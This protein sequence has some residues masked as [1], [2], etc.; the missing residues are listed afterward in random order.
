MN[1]Y[2]G[3]VK[4]IN[5]E[6]KILFNEHFELSQTPGHHN[7]RIYKIV[8]NSSALNRYDREPVKV[9]KWFN[10][11]WLYVEV[12]F[13]VKKSRTRNRQIDTTLTNIS[14]SVYEGEDNDEIKI[15]LFRAEW[16]DMN[17]N[18]EKHA[19]P[20]WHI[21]SSQAIEKSFEEYSAHFDNGDFISLLE[22]EKSKI[23]DVKR[24][25]FAINGNW[26]GN[27]DHIHPIQSA[28]QVSK[29]LKGLLSHIRYELER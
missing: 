28:E 17:D 7:V 6:C 23:I 12:K 20:H 4:K 5:T 18:N 21:T 26:Q 24:I 2:L 27:Q 8:G 25:H 14:L 11:F 9:L 15:Q 13:V 19:Q 10:N 3:I 29:W 1:D 16:D 22:E